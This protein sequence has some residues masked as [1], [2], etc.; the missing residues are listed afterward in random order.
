MF[1]NQLSLKRS[2]KYLDNMPDNQFEIIK[3]ELASQNPRQGDLLA[4]VLKDLSPQQV[5]K[6]KEKAAEGK[7]AL[8]LEQLR[9]LNQFQ[10]SSAEMSE[11]IEVVRRLEFAQKGPLSGY[12]V[13]GTYKT[14]TGETTIVAKKGCFIATAVYGSD[15]HPNVIVLQKFRDEHLEHN[16]SG[17]RFVEW[18]Y[19]VGPILARSFLAK[20]LSR[21]LIRGALSALCKSIKITSRGKFHH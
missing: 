9:K 15:Q 6:L 8:E 10:A 5:E 21:K 1:E 11:V 19:K 13:T 14:A 2:N 17:V 7:L 18:Y 3:K 4:V 20:G 16:K 12:K